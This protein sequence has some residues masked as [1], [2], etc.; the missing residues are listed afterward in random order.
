LR[1]LRKIPAEQLHLLS[2]LATREYRVWSEK[3]AK[4]PDGS[5]TRKPPTANTWPT[6]IDPFPGSQRP[7]LAAW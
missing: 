4:G 1:K 5:S 3:S 6:H 2:V 7:Q